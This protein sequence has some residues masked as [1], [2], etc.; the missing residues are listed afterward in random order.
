MRHSLR[1]VAQRRTQ[2]I[3]QAREYKFENSKAARN[4][5]SEEKWREEH[6]ARIIHL[7]SINTY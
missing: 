5:V 6:N 1:T 2:A 7:E 3:A 4:G